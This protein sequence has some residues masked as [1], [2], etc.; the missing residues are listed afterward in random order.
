MSHATDPLERVHL[1][2]EQESDLSFLLALYRSTR[3][4]ELSLVDWSEEQKS[5]FVAM[6]FSAQRE[7]YRRE[8][9][10]ARF[11]VI[12]RDA[13]PIGRLYVHERPDGIRIM[14]IVMTP[15]ARNL[16]IG[17]ALLREI[18]DRGA[19]SQ[20]PVTIHVER[21]NPARRLYERLG[22]RSVDGASDDSVYLLLE[23]RPW[24]PA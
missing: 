9:P 3:E 2:P 4:Q 19:R 18:L 13:L 22:F 20:R 10:R 23:A 6:Q 21:F 24:S 5:A 7:H 16:G 8:Y 14:D 11:D 17:G 15:A 12:E 1:R